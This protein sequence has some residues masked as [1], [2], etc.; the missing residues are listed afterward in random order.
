MIAFGVQI[1]LPSADAPRIRGPDRIANPEPIERSAIRS[2]VSAKES[3]ADRS[4]H[5]CHENSDSYSVEL[6]S[7]RSAIRARVHTQIHTAVSRLAQVGRK[8]T[9]L[10]FKAC[11]KARRS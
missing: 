5:G 7:A 3:V 4:D 10:R 11:F 9:A 8:P 1:A 6:L 2:A